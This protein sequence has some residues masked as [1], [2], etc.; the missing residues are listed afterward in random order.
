MLVSASTGEDSNCWSVPPSRSVREQEG[1]QG[2]MR[3][4][5]KV[6]K[7]IARYCLVVHQT[8]YIVQYSAVCSAVCSAART[9]YLHHSV[10]VRDLELP[11]CTAETQQFIHTVN[12]DI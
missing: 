7:N 10:A 8:V 11:N 5:E 9:D 2:K 6:K 4:L 1:E 12:S 3:R